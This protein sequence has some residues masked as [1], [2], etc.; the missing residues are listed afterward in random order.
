[1]QIAAKAAVDFVTREPKAAIK[2]PQAFAASAEARRRDK[3]Q[4]PEMVRFGGFLRRFLWVLRGF[5]GV[6]AKI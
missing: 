2:D 3:E 1:V 5:W 6:W 4:T